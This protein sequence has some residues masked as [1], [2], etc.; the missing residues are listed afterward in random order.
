MVFTIIPRC[1]YLCKLKKKRVS[2]MRFLLQIIYLLTIS[3]CCKSQPAPM[4]I[5]YYPNEEMIY[6]LR[7]GFLSLGEVN[8]SFDIDSLNCGSFIRANARS[9]GVA[10]LIKD[11][12]YD[13]GSCMDP[14]TG[15]PYIATRIVREGD[16]FDE[17]IVFY[18]HDLRPDSSV[19]VSEQFDSLVVKKN[20]YDILSAFY[21][22]RSNYNI[23]KIKKRKS[24]TLTTFFVTE[25][26]D[27]TIRY[28]GRETLNTIL[29]EKECLRFMPVTEV[30][31]FF[32]HND[33]MTIW[34]TN[35]K[36]RIPVKIYVDLKFG[37]LTADLNQYIPPAY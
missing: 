34:V 13:F 3:W 25:V 19:V 10:K 20:I 17:S 16:D 8:I 22:F 35:D 27:L 14:S 12:R 15:L 32:K 33:D 9:T 6:S 2:S 1:D 21:T 4:H 7:M 37:S 26:W 5:P 24:V 36:H 11:I 29:G 31:R 30:G 18:Y 28:D 23:G